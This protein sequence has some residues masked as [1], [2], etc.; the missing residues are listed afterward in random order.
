MKRNLSAGSDNR[1]FLKTSLPY[2]LAAILLIVGTFIG[3]AWYFSKNTTV[4]QIQNRQIQNDK[5]VTKTQQITIDTSNLKVPEPETVLADHQVAI[6]LAAQDVLA[7]SPYK[8]RVFSIDAQKNGYSVQKIIVYENDIVRI[9]LNAKDGTY[10][11]II[12]SL[13]IK[14]KEIASGSTLIEF[15]A[16]TSGMYPFLCSSCQTNNT[17]SPGGVIVVL[18]RT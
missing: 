3:S 4:I 15:Q 18:P 17:Q 6:P 10:D 16:L 8:L 1:G 7:G 2:V 9:N 13:G 12:P 5:V 11:L 14:S